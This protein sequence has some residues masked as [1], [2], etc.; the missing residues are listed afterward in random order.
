MLSAELDKLIELVKILILQR[1]GVWCE[2]S[3]EPVV[4]AFRAVGD[5]LRVTAL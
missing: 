4:S 5:E 3:D 2:P 1:G